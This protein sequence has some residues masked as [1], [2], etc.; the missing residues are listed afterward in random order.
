MNGRVARSGS[1][2]PWVQ[3][4]ISL[5]MA[6]PPSFPLEVE[7]LELGYCFVGVDAEGTPAV[8]DDFTA[9]GNLLE[10]FLQ[11]AD[12]NRTCSQDVAGVV[13]HGRA[14]VKHHDVILTDPLEEL[15]RANAFQAMSFF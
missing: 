6:L 13:F 2:L 9:A 3:L 10:P 8:R 11:F 7:T 4:N 14:H 5:D 15:G 1:S 12:R